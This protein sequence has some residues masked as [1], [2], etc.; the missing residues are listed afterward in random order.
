MYEAID[1]NALAVEG[2]GD[3]PD[4]LDIAR[5]VRL[6]GGR[7]LGVAADLYH[8]CNDYRRYKEEIHATEPEGETEPGK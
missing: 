7:L 8:D 2:L 1:I 5:E 4:F 6:L 3:H